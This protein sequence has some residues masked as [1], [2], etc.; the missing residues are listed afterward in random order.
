MFGR[1]N[2][3]NGKT[4]WVTFNGK[5][6][7]FTIDHD[8]Q[9]DEGTFREHQT[10]TGRTVY[11]E[12]YP[13]MLSAYVRRVMIREEAVYNKPG[14][15]E[16]K[17]AVSLRS[18]DGQD[19]VV[20]FS[21][22]SSAL[23]V[24]GALNAAD[25]S[26]PITLK[27]YFFE[28]GTK[29]KDAQGNEVVRDK[30]EVRLVGYQGDQK[31]KNEYGGDIPKAVKHEVKNP[32][33]GKVIDTVYDFTDQHE[34]TLN[35]ARAIDEK[36]K[37]AAT[38]QPAPVAPASQPARAAAADEGDTPLSANDI[39]GGDHDGGAADAAAFSEPESESAPAV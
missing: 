17:I 27:S 34:F 8:K 21:L 24:L 1:I 15:K 22:G 14:E 35:L 18:P 5:R 28:K 20:K 39:L 30:D 29:G 32:V 7:L 25:L 9:N 6:G 10:T 3:N 12:E 16:S 2:R 4:T 31:L 38:H 36:V 11:K 33:T 19:A 23:Q 37:S 13:D 26:Q